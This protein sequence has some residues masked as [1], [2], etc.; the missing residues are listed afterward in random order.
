VGLGVGSREI[1]YL[2]GQYHRNSVHHAQKG[3]GLLWGGVYPFP[4]ATA[5]GV[6]HFA[7]RVS[8]TNL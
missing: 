2:Y 3:R 5:W 1:G 7:R 4:Q 8:A 6:V